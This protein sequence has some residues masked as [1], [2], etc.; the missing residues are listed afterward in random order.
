MA[1][2]NQFS[3]S[4]R[5]RELRRKKKAEEKRLKKL[6]RKQGLDPD[7]VVRDPSLVGEDL[8]DQWGNPIPSST[9]APPVVSDVVEMPRVD[10][11][12]EE[13][14]GEEEPRSE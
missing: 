7:A 9:P 6:A 1:R 12:E 3:F 14:A 2:R 5:Q 11:E 4:K 10:E 8:K 13:E